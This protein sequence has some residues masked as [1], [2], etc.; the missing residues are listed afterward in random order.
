[1]KTFTTMTLASLTMLATT[2]LTPR[3]ADAATCTIS[4]TESVLNG[5]TETGGGVPNYSQNS[6]EP[7]TND[8]VPTAIGMVLGFWDANGWPCMFANTGPYTGGATPHASIR[9]AVE[10]FKTNLNYSSANGTTH[11]PFDTWGATIR[12][13]ASGRDSGASGWHVPDDFLVD[14]GDVTSEIDAGRPLVFNVLGVPGKLVT[15]RSPTGGAVSTEK[16]SHSMAALGYRR[17]VEGDDFWG[18]CVDWMDYDEF[19]VVLRSGWLNGGDSRVYYHWHHFDTKTAVKVDP[20]S[21]SPNGC[22]PACPY[23]EDGECDEP[24][25]LGW[26]AQG[27]DVVDCT[28]PWKNDGEC[29][30]PHL[31]PMYSDGND[32]P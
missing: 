18:S 8:C 29:D 19:F 24:D 26:C 5:G 31:C 30:A 21:T 28:C 22:A 10:Y 14:H 27:T 11:G 32:C 1:M 6:F 4:V 13:F 9:S 15:W 23:T 7:G 3:T 17:V 20:A 2:A 16:L 12:A 25:G